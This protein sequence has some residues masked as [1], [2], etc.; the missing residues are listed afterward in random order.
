MCLAPSPE[1]AMVASWSWLRLL[2][3]TDNKIL[4]GPP[5]GWGAKGCL[6][7]TMQML[8][9]LKSQFRHICPAQHSLPPPA[10]VIRLLSSFI[11][12]ML[13]AIRM[14]PCTGSVVSSWHLDATSC[15][16]FQLESFMCLGSARV[17]SSLIISLKGVKHQM[18]RHSLKNGCNYTPTGS[19]ASRITLR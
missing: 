7:L 5:C 17:C 8:S 3:S 16:F 15:T 6:G 9:S 19:R 18:G 11:W 10:H 4:K 13:L 14:Q 2:S 12:G 1:G